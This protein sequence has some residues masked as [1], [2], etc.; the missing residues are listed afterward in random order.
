MK[1][2][3]QPNIYHRVPQTKV[4]FGSLPYWSNSYTDVNGIVRSTQNTTEKRTD[5][6][7]KKLAVILGTRFKDYDHVNIMPMN[8]SDATELY[9][10]TDAFVERYGFEKF[11][12]RYTP[13]LATDVC[14]NIIERY[15]KR[16]IVYLRQ[17]EINELSPRILVPEDPSKYRDISLNRTYFKPGFYK[18][19]RL[20]DEYKGLFEFGVCDFQER[21][22]NMKDE[23]NSVV[24]IRNC[25]RQSFGDLASAIIVAKLDR[26]LNGASLL[27]TGDYDREHMPFFTEALESRFSEIERN[28]WGKINYRRIPKKYWH[29][30]PKNL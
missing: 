2:N 4:S 3:L 27:I 18:L 19:F 14:G 29:L 21:L 8:V 11:K 13:I 9:Y 25:L 1:V 16:G 30:L 26:V 20:K 6:N 22:R 15:P 5:L 23:G 17:D 12:S 28:V 10:I 7:Y 24:I